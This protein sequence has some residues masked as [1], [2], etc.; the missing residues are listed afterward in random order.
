VFVL[1]YAALDVQQCFST[2]VP[3]IPRVPPMAC[4][5]SAESS[6]GN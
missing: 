6:N 3:Q 2:G 1:E 5:G 4:K